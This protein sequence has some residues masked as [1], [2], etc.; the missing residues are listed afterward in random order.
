MLSIIAILYSCTEKMDIELDDTYTRLVVEGRFSTDTT[1]H[2]VRLTETSSYFYND[3]APPVRGAT[4]TISDEADT[5]TLTE[6][7]VHPGI[8]ETPANTYGVIGKNYQLLIKDVDI[9]NNGTTEEYSA[10]STIY[11]VNTIDSIEMEYDEFFDA[12]EVKIYVLDPPTEDYYLFNIYKN[13]VLIT[14]TLTEPL[15]VDDKFY[16]GNYTNGIGVGYLSDKKPEEKAFPGDTIELEMWRIN[17]DFYEFVRELEEATRPSTP[18][19]SGPAAN[20]KGNINNGA[21]GYF[22]TYSI[23]R[24][25]GVI[26]K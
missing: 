15:V 5:I 24:A 14:D 8:Y 26:K 22:A 16:N 11:P 21:V 23:S 19:F 20:V 12:W 3:V 18:L 25:K 2:Q 10:S 6:S 4:V 17:K 9:D 1:I 7:I 13:N